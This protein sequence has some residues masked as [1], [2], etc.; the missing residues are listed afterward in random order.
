VIRSQNL[1]NQGK[2]IFIGNPEEDSELTNQRPVIYQKIKQL[3]HL[4][5]FILNLGNKCKVKINV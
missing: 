5:I 3:L 2:N 4:N 1:K